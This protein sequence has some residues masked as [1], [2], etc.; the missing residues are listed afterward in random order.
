MS[1]PMDVLNAI[2]VSKSTKIWY[3]RDLMRI[4]RLVSMED[5]SNVKLVTILILMVYV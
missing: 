4:V 2:L 3:A 5:A 1:N